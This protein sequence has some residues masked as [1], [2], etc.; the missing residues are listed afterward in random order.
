MTLTKH[1]TKPRSQF[2]DDGLENIQRTIAE[3][4]AI[5]APTEPPQLSLRNG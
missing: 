2:D 5:E 3:Q 1:M 4:I